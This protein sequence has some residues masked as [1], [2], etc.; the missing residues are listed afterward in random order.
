MIAALLNP[1]LMHFSLH[2]HHIATVEPSIMVEDR[3]DAFKPGRD[4]EPTSAPEVCGGG[5][6]DLCMKLPN[7]A[8]AK[9]ASTVKLFKKN[10]F[11]L[12]S[13]QSSLLDILNGAAFLTFGDRADGNA[14][15][16]FLFAFQRLVW[17]EV[18]TLLDSCSLYPLFC[19]SLYSLLLL[20]LHHI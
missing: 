5:N 20:C 1:L 7:E 12:K 17:Q 8:E 10:R 3:E 2:H 18:P 9:S 15:S 16:L 4:E 11:E 13:F 19:F 6:K 14:V